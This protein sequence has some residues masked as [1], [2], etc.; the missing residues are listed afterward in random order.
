MRIPTS[1]RTTL[2]ALAAALGLVVGAAAQ[3]GSD[4]TSASPSVVKAGS[5]SPADRRFVQSAA[6]GGMAEVEL[7]RLAQDKASSD[8][9][10]AFGARMV[11]DHGKAN[12]TLKG[13]AA[14]QGAEVPASL[15]RKHRAT[16]EKLGKLSGAEFDRAYM[17]QMVADHEKTVGD[18]KAQ[19]EAGKNAPLKDFAATAL[20]TLQAHLEMA[21]SLHG[22]ARGA[23]RGGAGKS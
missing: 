5:T 7:G 11:E 23:K 9:V 4:G 19:A 13:I 17:K 12:E 1:P 20:P 18:F 2:V 3:T 10:K 21:K 8:E 15:D 14:S 22:A 6:M 16:V